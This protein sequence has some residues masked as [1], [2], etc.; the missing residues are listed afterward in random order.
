MIGRM[1]KALVAGALGVTGRAAVNYLTSLG[2]WEV[3]GLS[4]RTPEFRTS[5]KYIAVD[6]LNRSELEDRLREIADITH[7]FFAALQPAASFFDE[8]APNLAMLANTVEVVERSSQSLRKVLL[9]EGASSTEAILAPTRL[10]PRR[11]I[12]VICRRIFITTRK[13]TWSSARREKYGRG[14]RFDPRRFAALPWE[15]P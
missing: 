15:T 5:A 9:V 6:L 11:L 14:R 2:D 4:R 3:I 7:I 12:R 8:V 13:I 10:P 1:K